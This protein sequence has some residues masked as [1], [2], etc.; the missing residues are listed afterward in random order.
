MWILLLFVFSEESV[1][2]STSS[3][4]ESSKASE[5]SIVEPQVVVEPPKTKDIQ[6]PDETVSETKKETTEIVE[7]VEKEEDLDD[8][9]QQTFTKNFIC[10]VCEKLFHS[11]KELGQHVADHAE[12][13]PY[14]CEFCLLLFEKT[15]DLLE[16]RSSLHG[17]GKTYVCSVCSKEFVY[18]CNV[19]QHQEELHPGQQCSHTEEEKGKL[20]PQNYNNTSKDNKLNVQVEAK[21]VKKEDVASDQLFTTIKIMTSNNSKLKGP[22]VRMGINQHYPSFKPPP[23]P[24]HNRS[25]ATSHA[26]ATNFTT[27]NIP[28]TFSTAIRCTKCGKSFDN[29]PEL[30]QHILVCANASDKR[31]YTPKKNPIPLRHFAKGQNGVLSTTNPTNGLNTEK[32]SAEA[33]IK[34]KVLTKR[35]KKLAQKQKAMSLSSAADVEMFVCPHCKREFTMR[36]SRTKH[37]AVCPK[38]PIEKRK[39]G[40]ANE[41]EQHQL[42]GLAVDKSKLQTSCITIRGYKQEASK[43]PRWTPF[44]PA[45]GVN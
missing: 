34:L 11:M 22:D 40:V 26:S 32:M 2:L 3:I 42:K 25:P 21:V 12:K 9:Q 31:R 28:Q 23:F 14:K 29:M 5:T 33:K 10:N 44:S 15:A 8:S 24:Y 35:Q 4:L 41:N 43:G 45:S 13:W 7:K 30:H 1:L 6:E 19:K 39:D 16:H 17:V 36:R 27:H 37:M 38:K 18:L 20:R